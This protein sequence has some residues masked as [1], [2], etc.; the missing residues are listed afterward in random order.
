MLLENPL[1]SAI[2]LKIKEFQGYEKAGYSLSPKF[3]N[4]EQSKGDKVV[5]R[6]WDITTDITFPSG[7]I[8]SNLK[9][10]GSLVFTYDK[11]KKEVT[12]VET[13]T[14]QHG[15]MQVPMLT[16]DITSIIENKLKSMTPMQD[17]KVSFPAQTYL[18]V[19]DKESSAHMPTLADT[20]NYA[21]VESIVKTIAD[22][23]AK[24]K[25]EVELHKRN[26]DRELEKRERA[27]KKKRMILG[28]DPAEYSVEEF[29]ALVRPKVREGYEKRIANIERHLKANIEK[30]R[31]LVFKYATNKYLYDKDDYD[32]WQTENESII[33]KFTEKVFQEQLKFDLKDKNGICK[34]IKK[35][36]AIGHDIEEGIFYIDIYE[37]FESHFHFHDDP[38]CPYHPLFSKCK[39]DEDYGESYK[40]FVSQ[41][42]C[43][44]VDLILN[45]YALKN[46]LEEYKK[47]LAE[48][49][50]S[51]PE[52]A[53][54]EGKSSLITQVPH[55]IRTS[56]RHRKHLYPYEHGIFMI[57]PGI[58]K[59]DYKN[60]LSIKGGRQ[61]D[62]TLARGAFTK[63]DC[64]NINT[65]AVTIPSSLEYDEI[66]K[67][68]D[69][70]HAPLLD[71]AENL[72]PDFYIWDKRWRIFICEDSDTYSRVKTLLVRQ[73]INETE[74]GAIFRGGNLIILDHNYYNDY[75][76]NSPDP[77]AFLS[78]YGR[79]RS[80]KYRTFHWDKGKYKVESIHDLIVEAQPE[81]FEEVVDEYGRYRLTDKQPIDLDL[82]EKK[83]VG[84]YFSDK[85]VPEDKKEQY[86]VILN[87]RFSEPLEEKEAEE[88]EP[89]P[90]VEEYDD[91]WQL[92]FDFE[93][94]D[95]ISPDY[96]IDM[97]CNIEAND[98]DKNAKTL[99]D[100]MDT[101][102]R[103]LYN[104]DD[105]DDEDDLPF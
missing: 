50:T 25:Q 41:D 75:F 19:M 30:Y 18:A 79:N 100:D 43:K 14:L 5:F 93:Y 81:C 45:I 69:F 104:N 9:Y 67:L 62:V 85:E 39:F 26:Q 34:Q 99:Y 64:Y 10:N 96:C 31:Q 38:Q 7:I 32:R 70:V 15:L 61:E 102:Y 87:Q 53:L 4:Y 86:K 84:S 71:V 3:K 24:I 17:I 52:F 36:Q 2:D 6:V 83:I 44:G 49:S 95:E 60:M 58:T 76:V 97:E 28:L 101:L 82:L 63:S 80:K 47:Y 1:Y 29:D 23:E 77:F 11:I 91:N 90:L 40:E 37:M 12:I 56:Y 22:E 89:T 59:I 54:Q 33:E 42:F 57:K 20:P 65:Q 103:E 74:Q 35:L 105:S 72:Y 8:C 51:Y 55:W 92:S 21:H 94:E 73:E 66:V 46:Q 48:D 98:G 78:K 13:P 27:T 16:G 88:E 68:L